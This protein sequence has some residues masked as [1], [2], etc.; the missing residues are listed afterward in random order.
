MPPITWRI[1]GDSLD[2]GAVNHQTLP[3]AQNGAVVNL[4]GNSLA[5]NDLCIW[6]A[7]FVDVCQ[8]AV[9]VMVV[10][11]EDNVGVKGAAG[12]APG[13]DIDQRGALYDKT[14]MS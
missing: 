14:P 12:Y 5:A 4:S 2:A 1:G 9:I 10:A 13:V 3:G 7:Q 6:A 8:G 11:D